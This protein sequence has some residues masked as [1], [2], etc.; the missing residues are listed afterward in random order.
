MKSDLKINMNIKSKLIAAFLIVGLV[1]F[2]A[3][4]L[5]TLL[6]SGAEI[7]SQAFQKLTA[8]REIK[9]SGIV[10]YFDTIRDQVL[11]LSQDT[12]VIDAMREF[13]TSFADFRSD[14]SLSEEQINTLRADL[15]K[16]YSGQFAPEFAKQND[17][18]ETDAKS[19]YG[20]LD[21]DSV[22]L[23]YHYI[24]AN[25]NPLGEKDKLDNAGDGSAYSK[26]HEKY[27]PPIRS[28]LEKFG[29]Y[30]IFL[31]DHKSGDIVYSVFK[32]LD[33]ATSLADGPYAKTNFADAFRKA[34]KLEKAGEFVFVDFKQYLPS[35]NAPA[36][37]IAAPIFDGGEKLGVLMFQ[38]PLDRITEVM[39]E[40]AGLG[41]TGETYL[42][43]SD[44]LMRSDSYLDP[45]HHSVVASFRNPEKGKVETAASAA[46]IA[47]K[48]GAGIVMDYNG[49][50]VLSAYAPVDILG[51]K[52]AMLAEIDETEAFA[53]KSAMM[54]MMTAIGLIG[55]VIV[56]VCG[57]LMA[58]SLSNPI[59]AMTGAMRQLAEGDLETEVPAQ[60]R[61]DEI[62]DMSSAVQVFKENA[63][64][65]KA[66]EA[67]QEKQQ[68]HAEDEKRAMM[69]E[70][71]DDFDANV[72]GI[73]ETVSSASAEL[74]ATAQSMVSISEETNSQAN[75]VAAASEQTSANVQTVAAATE[76]MSNSIGEIN[77]QVVDASNASRKA[78]ADV[79]KTAEQITALAQ[80]ADKIGEVVSMI[81]DI[82]E[83]TNLL[84]LNATIESARAGE[85]GKGFAVVAAEVKA[86]ANE[87]AKAT[88]GISN[89]IEEIQ[90]ATGE[91]VTSIDDI[92]KVI[93]RLEENSTAIVAAMEEQGATTQEVARNVSEAASG[94]KEVSSN[95]SGV[96]QASQ[97]AGTAATQVTGAAS[98]LSKQA[99]LMK[100]EVS[101][102][103]EQIRAA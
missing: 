10:R 50:P 95:I 20:A 96:T 1:P 86:L 11:T 8:V 41:E 93:K 59:S 69:N 7:E 51:V 32:E 13:K 94:T 89:L 100:M 84:A 2:T 6:K 101:K 64:R 75:A 47:G 22:A 30:D 72:G 26:V 61:K 66:L 48:T 103:I 28:F 19:L 58:R 5:V 37:F 82:A 71:A 4:G 39:S 55:A 17:G 78:V 3:I 80:T 23:Q 29:F 68:K 43:G 83:Q 73:V 92:G 74:N 99:E 34:A 65:N 97:E 57:Y 62:G 33:Y 56:G 36:S 90:S 25:K 12:M 14:N 24:Q 81:S 21:S 88:E 16:Y 87:T 67:E 46:A 60:D 98:E 63:I 76:E 9:K 18:R 15:S 49:N 27:H 77:T 85:A 40:R 79:L 70:I 38:M 91:A 31:V 44:N 53:A 45:K 102:F 42:I 52:W 35:Y 54:W